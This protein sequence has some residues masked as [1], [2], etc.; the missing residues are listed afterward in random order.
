MRAQ[1]FHFNYLMCT[2]NMYV[3][4]NGIKQKNKLKEIIT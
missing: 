1:T 3:N 2:L 4:E